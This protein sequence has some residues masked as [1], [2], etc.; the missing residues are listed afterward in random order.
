[1][2]KHPLLYLVIILML[3]ALACN[4]G[5]FGSEEEATEVPETEAVATE[6]ATPA[7]EPTDTPT[8]EPSPTPEPTPTPEPRS[9]DE[10][11]A[12]SSVAMEEV[13]SFHMSM[14]M[15]IG[16]AAEGMT[17]EIP[18][19]FEGDVLAPDTTAGSFS[20]SFLGMSIE[21]EFVTA[22]GVTY[23]TNPETGEWEIS[24]GD[25]F[26]GLG[27]I[28]G[29]FTSPN[30]LLEADEDAFQDLEFV[31]EETLDGVRVY[32]LQGSMALEDMG[33][34]GDV[35]V[36]LW[37]GVENNYLRQMIVEGQGI[38]A[39]MG[40]AMMDLGGGDISMLVTL[41]LS[42]FNEPVDIVIPEVDEIIAVPT[43]DSFTFA[44]PLEAVAFLPDGSFVATGGTDG[45]VQLWS[46]DSP[47][48]PPIDLPGHDDWIRSIAVS[49]DGNM[50][51][52]SSD[53]RTIMVW[54]ENFEEPLAVLEGHDDWVRAVA[55]SPDNS[56]L[57][58]ASDDGTVRLWNT[59]DFSTPPE[60]LQTDGY[61]FTVAF[62]PD[63]QYIAAA[64][65]TGI[66]YLWDL[67]NFTPEPMQ[68]EGHEDWIR[69]VA[70]SPDGMYLASGSD[71]RS[72]LL[73][74]M[75]DMTASPIPLLGHTDWVRSV[76]FNADGS[77][78]ASASDDMTILVWDMENLDDVP[79][80]L[81]GHTGWVTGVAFNP[82]DDS[83]ASVAEDG[84]A[85][86]WY[87]ET[88]GEYIILGSGG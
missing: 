31:G 55:F 1:M 14:E 38:S 64:G 43:V 57:A 3:M 11:M 70:F 67:A 20:I 42:N 54:G 4:F 5:P 78:L 58:S 13:E 56:I 44:S 82:I 41:V 80:T 16:V 30:T 32:H 65:D 69:S 87:S 76:A 7:P 52:S 28:G 39:D 33:E 74:S 81:E 83:I 12:A 8:P 29:G 22:D 35:S 75:T 62:S 47:S 77:V 48:N 59:L 2:R 36:D 21:S 49:P 15:Q 6:P 17:M 25:A 51:A 10:L 60:V 23:M 50:L 45:V 66:I 53:D 26:M 79:F 19:T 63:G 73:W 84:T 68:L 24:S 71:D 18:I 9:A 86:L 27:D 88:P 34:A 46:V 85:R 40:D 37:I 61:L 72:V